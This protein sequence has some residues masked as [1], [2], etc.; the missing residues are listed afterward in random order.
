MGSGRSAPYPP[1]VPGIGIRLALTGLRRLP[2]RRVR[3]ATLYA[4]HRPT[5]DPR[6]RTEAVV[7]ALTTH[8]RRATRGDPVDG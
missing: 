4:M 2:L 6:G 8:A 3:S 7:E 5:H 1:R